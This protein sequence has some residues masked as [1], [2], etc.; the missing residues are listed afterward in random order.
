MDANEKQTGNEIQQEHVD[1]EVSGFK[2][3]EK[4]ENN[5]AILMDILAIFAGFLSPLIFFLTMK[6]KPFLHE[7]SRKVL[8]AT[9]VYTITLIIG[10]ILNAT[11]VL[12]IIGLPLILAV[13]VLALYS[14]IMAAI[15]NSNG[16]IYS[17]PFIPN[18]I[19]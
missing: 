18:L 1:I 9:I 10:T 15:K 5:L 11:I 19:K 8:N 6:D 12:A 7:Q 2:S 14:L 16:E 13:G 3:S 4:D 17:L